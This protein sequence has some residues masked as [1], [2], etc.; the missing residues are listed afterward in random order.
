MVYKKFKDEKGDYIDKDGVRFNVIEAHEAHTPLGL[1][2]GWDEYSNKEL[3]LNAYG[4]TF[5]P[6]EEK[7]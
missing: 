7:L 2:V 3:A 1:N 6:L 4:L 5:N